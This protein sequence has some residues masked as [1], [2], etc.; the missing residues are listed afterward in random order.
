RARRSMFHWE[1]PP[2]GAMTG[3]VVLVTGATGGLGEAAAR[4]LAQR[5]AEVWIVGRDAAR[6][7]ST[8][9]EMQ[10]A[11]TGTRVEAI[12]ADLARLDDVRRV[13]EEVLAR[14]GRLDALVHNAGALV[15]DLQ[16]TEDGIEITAQ[17]HVVAPFLL[18]T[19]LL[20]LLQATGDAR[21]VTVS[22][23]GM[24]TQALDLHALIAPPVPFNGSRAYANA[25]RAQVVLNG[26][27]AARPG[28]GGVAFHAMHPG[29]A[30]T[31]G[32]QASLPRFRS[33]MRPILRTPDEGADTIVWLASAPE[34]QSASGQFWLDRRP[35][36]TSPLPWTRTSADDAEHLWDWCSARAGITPDPGNLA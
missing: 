36:P 25:K 15:H 26:L 12:V 31:P 9:R 13:A 32:V 8:R 30:D 5:G 3:R 22:S 29:W 35:R 33:V 11:A 17:V 10:A 4:T 16:Y 23:G 20:P 14:T 21:V 19:L 7:E 18:T 27:W 1:T 6:T 34:P 2:A 24:Y 28:A